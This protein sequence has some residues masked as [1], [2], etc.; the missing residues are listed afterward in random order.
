MTELKM[1][2]I[3]RETICDFYKKSYEDALFEDTRK[4]VFLEF[5]YRTDKRFLLEHFSKTNLNEAYGVFD[6]CEELSDYICDELGK[7]YV[8][9]PMQINVNNEWV[10]DIKISFFDNATNDYD[11]SYAPVGS[12]ITNGQFEPLVLNVG[13]DSLYNRNELKVALM[14]E[15]THAYEDYNRRENG[16]DSLVDVG[17]KFGYF[18]NISGSYKTKNEEYV[19]SLLYYIT[20][21]EKNAH[22]AQFV[23]ELRNNPN[24]F[25]SVEEVTN[26]L[27]QTEI[28]T[29]YEAVN[30]LIEELLDFTDKDFQN[31]IMKIFKKYSNYNFKNFNQLC[32]WLKKKQYEIQRKFNTLIPKITYDYLSHGN[33]LQPT[34]G[35]KIGK[36]S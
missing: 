20:S 21:F 33:L 29:T 8:T 1:K 15:L 34:K 35:H 17:E 13:F 6:G 36:I 2:N 7:G 32:K 11:A 23:G 24:R 5:F 31:Y 19:S 28:Y 22:I 10:K 30:S 16:K 26:F 12:K 25:K 14:H 4:H 18:K 3:V 9:N 27:K